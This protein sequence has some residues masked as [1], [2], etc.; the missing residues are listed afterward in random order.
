[1][2]KLKHINLLFGSGC[3]ISFDLMCNCYHKG[4]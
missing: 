4:E 2:L 3:Y 1:M